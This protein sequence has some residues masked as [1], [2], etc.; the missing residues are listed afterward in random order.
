[1]F[2]IVA[3]DQHQTAASV[4]RS[5]V[6]HRQARLAAAGV[7]TTEAVGAEAAHQPGGGADQTEDNQK[8]DE[9]ARGQRH[10]RTEEGLEHH[11][12]PL[13]VL[14]LSGRESPE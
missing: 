14:P 6:D 8:G 2:N 11:S 4:H 10:L 1:M 3:P 12:A 7:A 5:G 9:E 13:F